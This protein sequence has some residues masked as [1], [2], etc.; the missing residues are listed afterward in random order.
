MVINPLNSSSVEQLVLKEFA[1]PL[2]A[3]V[4]TPSLFSVHLMLSLVTGGHSK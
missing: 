1:W 3:Q 2:K 4:H